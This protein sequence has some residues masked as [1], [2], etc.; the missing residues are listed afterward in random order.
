ML[1]RTISSWIQRTLSNV[2]LFKHF[3]KNIIFII[4]IIDDNINLAM[5]VSRSLLSDRLSISNYLFDKAVQCSTQHGG[6]QANS[7]NLRYMSASRH[8]R[9]CPALLSGNLRSEFNDG[10]LSIHLIWFLVEKT[11]VKRRHYHWK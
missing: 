3:N 11:M 10:A 6:I 4:F 9:K 1:K 2:W 5:I 8:L 7:L